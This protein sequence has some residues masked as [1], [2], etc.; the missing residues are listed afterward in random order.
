[1]Q[2]PGLGPVYEERDTFR[3]N[4]L[5]SLAERET[6]QIK[7]LKQKAGDLMDI[8]LSQPASR[9]RSTAITNLE[10]AVMWATKGITA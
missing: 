3:L 6:I 5:R 8:I 10:Q 9:D 2:L 4:P 7:L 1:M